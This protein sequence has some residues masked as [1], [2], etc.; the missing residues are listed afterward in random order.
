MEGWRITIEKVESGYI[1]DVPEPDDEL[2]KKWVRE[3]DGEDELKAIEAVLWDV[4]GYFGHSGS[5]HDAER[6]RI[7][8]EKHE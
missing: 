3:E 8:R 5:K 4:L 1:L 2:G 6:I 7:V